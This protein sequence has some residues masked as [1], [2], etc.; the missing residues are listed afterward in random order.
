MTLPVES[1]LPE[2]LSALSE[3]GQAV[4]VA[5]PGS[6]K[7]TVIPLHLIGRSG[8]VVMLEPRRVATRAAARRMASLLGEEVGETIGYV[9]RDDRRTG[10]A[11]RIEVVT[12]GVLTRRLQTD[13]F[14]TGT[15]VVIFDEFH[16]RNLQT[17]L[18][19][20]LALDVRRSIRPDLEILV[21]S[22]TIDASRIAGHL[23]GAKVVRA[24][25]AIH[26]VEIRWLPP[27]RNASFDGHVAATINRSLRQDEGD[28]L[29]FLPGMAEMRRVA[30]ALHGGPAT[31]HL[32]HGSL[33]PAE[34]DAALTPGTRRKVILATDIAESSLTV[35]G[36]RVVIDSGAA[37][38]PRFD[39]RTGMTRLQTV[40]ISRASADQR[41]GRAGRLGPGVAYRLWSKI[42]HGT[43]PPQIEAEIGQVD[44]A[45]LVLEL[46]LWGVGDP[47]A[48]PFL[49]PPPARAVQGARTLLESL[50]AID[51]EGAITARGRSMATLPLHP[52]LGAMVVDA[53]DDTGLACVLAALIGERDPFRGKPDEL[54]IDLATRVAVIA[55]IGSHPASDPASVDRV[56]RSAAD[57][58]RR[59]G[60][61]IGTVDPGASGRMLVRAFP[62]R[63]AIRRGTPGRFQIRAGPTAWCPPQDPLAIE[64]FLVAVD[65]DGKRKDAR[66]RLAAALDHQDLIEEFGSEIVSVSTLEWSGDRL[67]DV[68]E[69]RLGG[70]VLGSRTE[71]ATPR[72]AVVDALLERLR[73]QGI[74]SLPWSENAN[75]IRR[76]VT[77]LHR[78]S[79]PPWPDLSDEALTASCG[80]WLG[81]RLAGCTA[82]ADLDGIDL[83]KVVKSMLG[84]LAS[85]LDRL[86]PSTVRLPGGRTVQLDYTGEIPVLAARVQ[87]LFGL[88]ETPL[89]CG[90]PVLVHLLS[91]AGRPVQ[92]TRDL[93]RFWSGSW[94]QV[95]KEMAGRY[96]KHAWPE[97]PG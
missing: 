41:A 88:H 1:V 24:D 97:K 56:R 65:L 26:P 28:I 4:L 46:A 44:L 48:L 91:P 6:G 27:A 75:Q 47:D 35:E 33:G 45:G 59:L 42:E 80:E 23:G 2:V 58:A 36:V 94:L 77:F 20:A 31:I 29:V 14:L 71:R 37:R 32:L 11:T 53:G 62:D 60:R 79:G 86:A 52:R 96:P 69:D 3:D 90:E 83:S 64:Q 63:L 21:M 92:I 12:E 66:I 7:T 93:E 67:V 9:T 34:Q 76:R 72:Q 78:R 15:S 22:A 16:E 39:P 70:I 50:G 55:G 25:G 19:L 89:V 85:Q 49:D 17:D 40:S 10:P 68:F 30:A 73:R 43:R 5:P 57:L 74:G 13:P 38:A 95:R 81:P 54:P 61:S 51:E 84:P 8:R 87:D 18:G 82:M